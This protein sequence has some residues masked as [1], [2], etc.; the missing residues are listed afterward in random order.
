[1]AGPGS[2]EGSE[3]WGGSVPLPLGWDLG[4]CVTFLEIFVNFQV[5][6]QGFIH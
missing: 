6:M 5:K 3:M 4:G 2:H 1:V